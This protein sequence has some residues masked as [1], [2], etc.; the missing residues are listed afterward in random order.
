MDNSC[1][2]SVPPL[3]YLHKSHIIHTCW[4]HT[5]SLLLR[6][7]AGVSPSVGSKAVASTS[8]MV[9]SIMSPDAADVLLLLGATAEKADVWMVRESRR[10]VT[11]VNFMGENTRYFCLGAG[12]SRKYAMCWKLNEKVQLVG[13]S[14][15]SFKRRSTVVQDVKNWDDLLYHFKDSKYAFKTLSFSVRGVKIS[16]MP[17][18]FLSL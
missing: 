13:D 16:R 17:A 12:S 1:R 4:T 5:S 11:K 8:F 14:F 2:Q 3:A 15:D 6:V 10:E 18:L 9:L 7:T